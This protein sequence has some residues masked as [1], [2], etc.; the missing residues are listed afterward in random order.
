MRRPTSPSAA[1]KASCGSRRSTRLASPKRSRQPTDIAD[2]ISDLQFTDA[3][4]VPFQFSRFVRQHLPPGAFVQSSAGVTLTDLDG[5]RS[6]DLT[7]SYG[8][9]VFGYDFYKAAIERG[10][11]RVQDLGP[12]LGPYHPV[13]A[14]NVSAC[15]RSAASTKCRSICRAPRR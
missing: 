9:N 7:G 2:G 3:Y 12:V 4:R 5:N 15:E 11:R 6:Y 1:A 10:V 14:D 8:V 13:V